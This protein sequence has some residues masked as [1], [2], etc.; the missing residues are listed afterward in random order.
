MSVISDQDYEYDYSSDEDAD[1]Y[2]FE[3]DD[4]NNDDSRGQSMEWNM[5]KE[6][7]NTLPTNAI[8]MLP[9]EQLL[10]EMNQRLQ[11]VTEVLQVPASAAAGRCRSTVR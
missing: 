10:P 2:I 5:L 8:S 1:D 3:E 9:A 11:E 4:G 7:S 6:S